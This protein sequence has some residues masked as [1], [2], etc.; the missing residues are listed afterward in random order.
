MSINNERPVGF[1]MP[2]NEKYKTTNM[3]EHGQDQFRY[4]KDK[5]S[6]AEVKDQT[7]A[8]EFHDAE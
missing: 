1:E 3:S 2:L 4:L 5:A 8:S 7:D 6:P